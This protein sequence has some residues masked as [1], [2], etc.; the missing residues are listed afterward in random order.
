ME[1]QLIINTYKTILKGETGKLY[2]CHTSRSIFLGPFYARGESRLTTD[3]IS[4]SKHAR[5]DR[6]TAS[7]L[8]HK[9]ARVVWDG[10]RRYTAPFTT[11]F[12]SVARRPLLYVSEALC[13]NN[14]YIHPGK[15]TPLIQG[16]CQKNRMSAGHLQVGFVSMEYT[17]L[18]NHGRQ[19]GG[20]VGL[21]RKFCDI[22][23]LQY[24]FWCT[25]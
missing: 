14:S 15:F 19:R 20:S 1:I 4:Y 13:V 6:R 12:F 16:R 7:A 3:D 23:P 25:F 17:G 2:V 22:L 21:P 18:E 8:H 11:T 10:T 24:L 9:A 5:D